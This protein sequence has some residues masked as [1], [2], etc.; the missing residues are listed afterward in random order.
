MELMGFTASMDMVPTTT[1]I[2]RTITATD[3]VHII[4]AEA[5][6]DI[7]GKVMVGELQAGKATAGRDR[8]GEAR[9]CRAT[10]GMEEEAVG[11]DVVRVEA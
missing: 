7:I 5:G 1:D 8:V 10:A 2:V 11:E 9:A 4:M 3:I 6:G